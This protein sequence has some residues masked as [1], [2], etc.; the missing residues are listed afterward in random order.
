MFLCLCAVAFAENFLC[1][2]ELELDARALPAG[3]HSRPIAPKNVN[4]GIPAQMGGVQTRETGR[5]VS[6]TGITMVGGPVGGGIVNAAVKA[7]GQVAGKVASALSKTHKGTEAV[8]NAQQKKNGK[9]AETITPKNANKGISPLTGGVLTQGVQK[10]ETKQKLSVT[11]IT[12]VG[13]PVGGGIVNAAIKAG[14]QV[15]GKVASALSKTH[16]G[17]EAAAN[18]QKKKNGKRVIEEREPR[19]ILAPPSKST[20]YPDS[21]HFSFGEYMLEEL[22]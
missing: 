5:K 18:V 3:F 20:L 12:M 7:G 8:A 14:G 17:T 11:G 13:G 4:K 1:R 16:K 19:Y 9:R 10:Q 6:V 22:D 15:A 21:S 2:P